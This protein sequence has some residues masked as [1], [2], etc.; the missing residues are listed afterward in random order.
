MK[1]RTGLAAIAAAGLILS[2]CS[3]DDETTTG[4]LEAPPGDTT[5]TLKV[6]LMDGSQTPAMVDQVNAKFKEAYPNV[7][8]QVELQQWGG[9]QDKLTTS[10]GTDSTPDV[11]EIG[12]TYTAKYIDSGLL[13]DLTSVAGDL[14]VANMLPGLQASGEL[15]GVRAGI[16]YYGAVRIVI[17]KMSD[18]EKA[19]ITD[20]PTSLAELEDAAKKLQ[21]SNSDNS[22]YSAFF[23]P[24]KFWYGA[25]PFIW[26]AGG[27][28]ATSDDSG[29]WTGTLNSPESQAGLTTLKR[30]VDNY[31][32]APKDGDET[33]NP[34]AFN[35]GDVGMMIDMMWNPGALNAPGAKFEGD[36]GVFALPGTES[37]STSPA[38]LGGSD[39]A[40]SEKS[41]N[42]GLAV[43]WLKILT[44]TDVQTQLAKEKGFIPNQEA[45]FKGHEGDPFLLAADEASKNSKFTPVSPNWA[46]VESSAVMQD[47]LVKIFTERQTIEEA[48]TEASDAITTTLN[49]G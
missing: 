21:E 36:V 41:P 19:G 25:L 3:S 28:I 14:G 43:E 38:F 12:N 13:A 30:L 5:A 11:V 45:A 48:T 39:L 40:V 9:I 22:K 49:G 7:T 29:T 26:D 32:K 34:D 42:K 17:Y 8:V 4:G 2:G 16:P 31:S 37:G 46:N 20:V 27:D 15:D 10:L 1:F 23:F 18:F 33:K 44:G 47:M 6:W 35:T 24:G